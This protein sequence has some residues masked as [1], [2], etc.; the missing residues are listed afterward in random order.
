MWSYLTDIIAVISSPGD[1]R[2]PFS[3]RCT[4]AELATGIHI[5]MCGFISVPV[6]IEPELVHSLYLVHSAGK[7]DVHLL[8]YGNKQ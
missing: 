7:A 6:P 4:T 5:S 2:K 1:L 8:C 3:S